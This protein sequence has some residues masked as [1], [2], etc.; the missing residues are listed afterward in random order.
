MEAME[1]IPYSIYSKGLNCTFKEQMFATFLAIVKA[2]FVQV[3]SNENNMMM[4]KDGLP[5]I[6]DWGLGW[7]KKWGNATYE[8][9]LGGW[10]PNI[11]WKEF[12]RVQYQNIADIRSSLE[13]CGK[14]ETEL[15]KE[16]FAAATGVDKPTKKRIE[17]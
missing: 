8:N 4:N 1:P 5:I 17:P 12:L 14:K 6:I 13:D 10:K 2:G 7:S 9:Y 11:D 15:E 16:F 3:D